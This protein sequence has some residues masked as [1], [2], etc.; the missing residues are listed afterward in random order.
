MRGH[1]F[2]LWVGVA[3]PV[4]ADTGMVINVTDLKDIVTDVLDQYD[5]RHLNTQLDLEPTTP[6]IARSLWSDLCSR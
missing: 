6:N 5:H 4:Q 1:N 2:I 3:G